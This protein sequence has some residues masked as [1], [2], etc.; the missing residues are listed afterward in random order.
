MKLQLAYDGIHLDDAVRCIE[1]IQEYVDIIEIGTPFVL[2]VGK[3]FARC[4]DCF[5]KRKFWQI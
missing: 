1:Q 3:E 4:E 5:R 2:S